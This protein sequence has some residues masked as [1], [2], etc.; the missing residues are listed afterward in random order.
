MTWIGIIFA[1]LIVG[2]VVTLQLQYALGY[3]MIYLLVVLVVHVVTYEQKP[4]QEI[5]EQIQDPN[6]ISIEIKGKSR[7]ARAG[8]L[9]LR[10]IKE[11]PN[12]V[13]VAM[14]ASKTHGALVDVVLA[15]WY[16][17]SRMGL[18]G[19]KN[20]I[21]AYIALD[22]IKLRK[23]KKRYKKAYT[24]N[25][26][27]LLKICE[28][29]EYDCATVHGSSTG[30][31]GPMQFMPSTWALVKTDANGDGKACPLD[32]VDAMHGTAKKLS[33]AFK[34]YGSWDTA[35]LR[36]AGVDCKQNRQYVARTRLTR[37]IFCDIM[38]KAFDE[39]LACSMEPTQYLASK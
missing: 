25:E 36:Y 14:L 8:Q 23:S 29:C 10:R 37:P 18:G 33:K 24:R 2:C 4:M 32:I 12:S 11:N 30:A 3:T 26:E 19:D 31:L 7:Q 13:K 27:D 28:Q 38:R 34:R 1:V 16:E 17:E 15:H 22:Q 35:I 9:L 21:G 5:V 39:N 20:G 6:K